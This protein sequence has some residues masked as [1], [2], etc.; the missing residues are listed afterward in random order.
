[1]NSDQEKAEEAAATN[2]VSVKVQPPSTLWKVFKIIF[3]ILNVITAIAVVILILGIIGVALL[4][5]KG[6]DS[7]GKKFDDEEIRKMKQAFTFLIPSVVFSTLVVVVGFVGICK[8][9][10]GCLYAYTVLVIFNFICDLLFCI[11][12]RFTASVLLDIGLLFM[13]YFLINEIKKTRQSSA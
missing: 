4:I 8:L 12:R 13:M 2:V 10:L 11:L 7:D 9:H 6:T 3:I 5:S 1:M